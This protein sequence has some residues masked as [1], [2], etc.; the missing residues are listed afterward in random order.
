M[1]HPPTSDG[2]W[3]DAL[4]GTPHKTAAAPAT[5]SADGAPKTPADAAAD[6]AAV[7]PPDAA[8]AEPNSNPAPNSPA[9]PAAAAVKSPPLPIPRPDIKVAER[10][11]EGPREQKSAA[12]KDCTTHRAKGYRHQSCDPDSAVDSTRHHVSDAHARITCG[13]RPAT[14][15]LSQRRAKSAW[16]DRWLCRSAAPRQLAPRFI[17]RL[18][19]ATKPPCAWLRKAKPGFPKR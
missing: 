7:K 11:S 10:E 18:D 4:W 6:S 17:K 14:T 5:A 3:I 9:A 19:A 15:G 2:F 13:A 8:A 16:T 12:A 1:R